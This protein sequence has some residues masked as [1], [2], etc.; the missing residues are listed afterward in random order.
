MKPVDFGG[1]VALLTGGFC[2][3]YLILLAS[4]AMPCSPLALTVLAVLSLFSYVST[5]AWLKRINKATN[6][7][8]LLAA[9]DALTRVWNRGEFFRRA[10]QERD[11]AIRAGTPFTFIVLDLDNF[12]RLNDDNGHYTGD[13][14]LVDVA[15]NIKAILRP[16]D[17]L[18]RLG[19]EEFAIMLPGLAVETAYQTAERVRQA[20]QDASTRKYA[21]TASVGFG[22]WDGSETIAELYRRVDDCLFEA[23]RAGKNR[24]LQAS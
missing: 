15:F 10:E 3:I 12:K 2:N 21:V 5:L 8:H 20:V 7:L 16:Y 9:T 17:C 11:R 4:S 6:A 22:H 1:A 24:V 13:Q 14:A 18:G 19:G 23:K